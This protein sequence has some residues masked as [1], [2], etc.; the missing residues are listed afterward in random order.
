M[1]TNGQAMMAMDDDETQANEALQE[2]DR[3]K[4]RREYVAVT[5]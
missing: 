5:E 3:Q 1:G 2:L 4:R